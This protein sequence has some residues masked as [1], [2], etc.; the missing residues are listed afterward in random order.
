MIKNGTEEKCIP[1][2]IINKLFMNLVVSFHDSI[3]NRNWMDLKKKAN[4][5]D[6]DDGE[7]QCVCV[8][9]CVSCLP[10]QYSTIL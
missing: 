6:D 7:R 3:I 1:T 2:I 5:D 9:V 8:E 4:C 10:T